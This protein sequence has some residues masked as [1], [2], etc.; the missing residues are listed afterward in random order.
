[1]SMRENNECVS[2]DKFPITLCLTISDSTRL[3]T[4]SCHRSLL[5]GTTSTGILGLAV[6]NIAPQNNVS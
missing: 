6:R 4:R 5:R 2:C 3:V 1:M